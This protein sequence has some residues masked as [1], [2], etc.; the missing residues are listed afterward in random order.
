[1][2]TS[3][4]SIFL[5]IFLIINS[6]L[7]NAQTQLSRDSK[8][9]EEFQQNVEKWIDAYNSGDAQNLVS[10]YSEDATYS[11][12]HVPGLEA[13]GRDALISNFQKGISGGG[14]LDK[15]E[16]F[17]ANISKDMASLYCFYQAT[18]NGVTV[19][20]RNLLVLRK[21]KGEW[22]IFSHMTVV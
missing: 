8:Q 7:T 15:I 4:K 20:G 13:I 16:I 22:L 3:I 2:K 18:N 10:L 14:H 6:N 5:A 1:M 11:S 12:S 17:T 19:S 21:V 9:F